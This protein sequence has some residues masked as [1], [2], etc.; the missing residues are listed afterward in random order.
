MRYITSKITS[1]SSR[2]RL[3]AVILCI[4]L[5]LRL[6]YALAQ[7]HN[8]V[9]MT[10]GGD[11]RWY[12]ENGRNLLENKLVGPLPT[13]PL[14]LIVV[15]AWQ[16]VTPT[17]ITAV[18]L[19]RLMQVLLGTV[20][21]Y[22]GYR[23]ARTLAGD[24]R[25]GL[26]A[27]AVLAV[28]PAFVVESAQ[29]VTE[30]LYIFLVMCGIWIY[31]DYV[32]P[33][34]EQGRFPARRLALV[35]LVLALATL[36]RAVLLLF[37]LGLALHLMLLRGW[38]MGLKQSIVIL[39]VYGALVSTWTIHNWVK[40]QRLVIGSDGMA[41][42][43]YMG[44]K[45]EGW[46]GP[47]QTDAMLNE[48]VPEL[49]PEEAT[50]PNRDEAFLKGASRTIRQDPLGYVAR[51]VK[52]VVKAYVQPHGTVTFPGESVRDLVYDWITEKRSVRGLYDVITAD[53]FWPK[54][55]I[56]L[57]HFTGLLFGAIGM[58]VY[59]RRWHVALPLIGFVVYTSLIHLVLMAIPRYIFPVEPFFW[60]FASAA[61]LLWWERRASR[62]PKTVPV[63][64]S[65]R[66]DTSLTET[67][68]H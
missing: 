3:L 46:Q 67:P 12:L 49:T 36:T 51:R 22:L 5:G 20:T 11:T 41:S 66:A 8:P 53:Y 44:S 37:P 23:L 19:I 15:G 17:A 28:S 1:M 14:Y 58:W 50:S 55:V 64:G 25:A 29:I 4:A 48:D 45:E 30:T 40:W 65:I 43:I 54:L 39:A 6:V 34:V 16:E 59:R 38:R 68:N 27:A 21:S 57:F 52:D 7:E 2:Q 47:D 61:G 56:Y 10:S 62:R 13:A 31:L 63:A 60:V 33:V 9:D 24:E 35:G 42:F 26:V 18:I 32:V